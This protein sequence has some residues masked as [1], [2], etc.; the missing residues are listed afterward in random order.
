V[1]VLRKGNLAMT[2]L[3]VRQTGRVK[4]YFTEKGF[5]F[6]APDSGG[7]DVFI[8]IS[9][10]EAGGMRLGVSKYDRLEFD[11]VINPAN[12][13]AAARNIRRAVE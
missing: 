4:K 2:T 3:S 12:G 10:L 6:V 9:D 13:K 11:L 8:H 5:G 7:P 1:S